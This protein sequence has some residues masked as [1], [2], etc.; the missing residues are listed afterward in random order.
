VVSIG[1][2]DLNHV[3]NAIEMVGRAAGALASFFVVAV[4]LLNTSVTLGLVVLI[5]VPALLVLLGPLLKPLQKRNL[6]QREMMGELNAL[7]SD[8][9]G[10]SSSLSSSG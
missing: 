6:A 10:A 5:G 2:S 4:I 9:V 1:S 3:G 8:I 7:A